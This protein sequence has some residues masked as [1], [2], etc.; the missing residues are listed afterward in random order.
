MT[1]GGKFLDLLYQAFAAGQITCSGRLARLRS[2]SSF[3]RLLARAKN[4]DWVVY[5]KPPF[6]GP[7]Q[8][9]RYLARYT[10]RVAIA[11]YRILALANG[12]VTFRYKDYADNNRIK[13]MSLPA[14]VFIRRFLMHVLPAGFTRIRYYGLMANRDRKHHLALCRQ[15]IAEAPI[16]TTPLPVITSEE[17]DDILEPIDPTRCPACRIQSMQRLRT[18]ARPLL[19]PE[20]LAQPVLTWDT[21]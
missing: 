1:F 10:H 21:S 9:V 3:K 16:S 8:V 7:A 6:G 4:H 13:V 20:I 2:R 19:A 12:R 11:N 5:S 18:H 15:R 17:P 14:L